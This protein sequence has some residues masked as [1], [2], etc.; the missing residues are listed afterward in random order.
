MKN[1]TPFLTLSIILAVAL[2]IT[3]VT[4]FTGEVRVTYSFTDPEIER[5]TTGFSQIY[6]PAT[7]QR[8]KAGEPSYPFCGVQILLP[9]GTMASRVRIERSGWTVLPGECVLHPRQH[10][11]PLMQNDGRK[12]DL[13]FNSSAYEM[14]RWIHPPA[15]QFSTQYLRGHAIV[16]GSFSPAGF[17]PA[18]RKV[19][20]YREVTL[21]IETTAGDHSINSLDLLRTDDETS[22][23]IAQLV[24]NPSVLSGYGMESA[25]HAVSGEE[26]EYLIITK[27]G[28]SDDFAPLRDFYL[29]RGIRTRIMTVEEIESSYSGVDEPEK[30]RNAIREEYVLHGITYVL[31]GGD[32]DGPPED[33]K[34]VPYR[35]LSCS[36]QS[37]MLH[38]ETNI[39]ADLY[40]ASLD[41]SW[42][43]DGDSLWGEPGEEDFYSE[44][45]IGR[46]CVDSG[47]EVANFINKTIT[48]QDSPLP[49]QLRT[50]LLLGEKLWN[51]PL[52]YGGD[53]LDQLIGPCPENGF[54]TY[55]VPADFDIVKFYDRNI[56]YW[57]K[58]VVFDAVN[59]GTNWLA[60]SGHSNWH[61]AM[62]ILQTDVND[63]NFTNDGT[64]AT[65]PIMY[66][67]GCYA[68]SFDNRSTGVYLTEDCIGEEMVAIEHCAVAFIGNSRY[69][70][71]TEGT[72]NG[73]SHH[74]TRE[75]F[76]AIFTEGYTT[77]GA[78]NQRSK[79]ETVPFIDLPNEYEPG[80][81]RWC[82]Y[83][84]NLI[85]DPAL[86]G[87][88][89][90]PE[91]LTV[92][93][94]PAIGRN[95]PT[96]EI[97]AGVAEAVASLFHDGICYGRGRADSV[98]HIILPLPFAF[99]D[100]VVSIELNVHAH[101]HYPYR[102]S[103]EVIDRS[104]S[105]ILTPQFAFEQNVPNPFNPST[106]IR[107]SVAQGGP[108]DLRAYNAAGREVDCIF[109]G[110]V[111]P[112]THTFTWRPSQLT[113][114]LY[115]L[116]LRTGER[117]F[118]RKAVLLR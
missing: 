38:T 111:T 76:D 41:G 10:P 69:G 47:E 82:F 51:D 113:S 65:F 43:D 107:F 75:F 68:G 5:T 56:G 19:G 89:D 94:P 60:H 85:G 40:F 1:A 48:Y 35:G 106:R 3:P 108:A 66:S 4:G 7:M 28:L 37:S 72:T 49:T 15:S 92:S 8:G 71:F 109:S 62:R 44:I 84:L 14:T 34:I 57:S 118:T 115:F 29:R 90:T 33:P 17:H 102:D 67:I 32:G 83:T 26:Y 87:W 100:T 58:S 25:N 73:P 79:D 13:L 27:S 22:E 21:I 16:V 77:L 31:L 112:G 96:I 103:I 30:I 9:P 46:A 52:T 86:D 114:G 95:D 50:A 36:V 116:V 6:F 110:S 97:D 11:V 24:D 61:Y 81:H 53:E 23:R 59:A 117:V 42:N 55:G 63:I 104:T 70:W 93:H 20:Y 99:P 12:K 45:A 74:Y 88:T 80:A 105:E 91:L 2:T 101:N 64:G 98:G 18:A 54:T 78:A 39:P